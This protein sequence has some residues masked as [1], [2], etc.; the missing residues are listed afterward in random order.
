MARPKLTNAQIC[1][2]IKLIAPDVQ[3][4]YTTLGKVKPSVCIGMACVESRAGTSDLMF[5]HCGLWGQKVGSGKT[6]L[7]YWDGTS[8]NAKTKEEYTL[9]KLSE[10]RDNFRSYSSI[11]QGA[12]NYYEL[13]NT[14]LYAKVKS[15]ADPE[16][17]MAQI[18]A[19]GY[20]TS[21]TEVNSVLTYINKFNL[22]QY[23]NVDY[24]TPARDNPYREPL[25]TLRCGD[26]NEG[27]KWLQYELNNE[28]GYQ[29]AVDGWYGKKTRD[30]IKDFQKNRGLVVDGI[31][32][33]KTLEAF[34]LSI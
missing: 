2:F 25:R 21:S 4:A 31:C 5:S 10:I 14:K 23:D 28:Y 11:L 12:C 13:L 9:G 20:M 27:V 15:D 30:A 1:N 19:C 26:H 7:K 33:P 32:G 16:T 3:K 24:V 22:K 6:A 17:Q 18:K 34:G 29:L 8:Y